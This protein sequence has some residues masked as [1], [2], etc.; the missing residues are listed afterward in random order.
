MEMIDFV[1]NYT[2]FVIVIEPAGNSFI[3]LLFNP[4][5]PTKAI[6]NQLFQSI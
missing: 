6:F 5:Y 1:V 3:A 4:V 2:W